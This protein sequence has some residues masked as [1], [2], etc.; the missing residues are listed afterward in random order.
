M[1][2]ITLFLSLIL[3]VIPFTEAFAQDTVSIQAF[4]YLSLTRDTVVGFPQ[5]GTSYEKILMTYNMRCHGGSVSTSG[6]NNGPNQGGCGEWDYSCNTYLTDSSRVD[7][8]YSFTPS[9]SVSG[10]NG[11]TL[12]YINQTTFSYLQTT[13][14]EVTVTSSN[15]SNHLLLS[16]A[17][18]QSNALRTNKNAGKSQFLYTASE[19]S[20]AGITAGDLFAL[21]LKATNSAR[22]GFLRVSMKNTNDVSLSEAALHTNGFTEVYYRNTDFIAG[23]NALQFYQP[24]NWDGTSNVIVEF[25]FTNSTPDLAL[26]LQGEVNIDNLALVAGGN[27]YAEFSGQ[28]LD[29]DPTAMANITN[30]LTITAWAYGNPDVLPANTYFLE[31]VNAANQRQVNVHL[32]WS[33]SRV[34]WDC[35]GD[36]GN[37]DRID[38]LATTA[39]IEGQWNHWAFTKNANTGDMKIFLN[40]VLW[41]SGTA[42][43]FTMDITNFVIGHSWTGNGAYSGSIDELTVWNKELDEATIQAWMNKTI[44][45]THPN[46]INLMAYFDFNEG[47]GLSTNDQSPNNSTGTFD[48]LPAWRFE[49]GNNIDRQFENV[50]FRPHVTFVQGT[51][52]FSVQDVTVMDSSENTPHAIKEFAIN[53]MYG[54]AVDD[55]IVEQSVLT[56]W[57]IGPF[58]ILDESGNIVGTTTYTSNG[59]VTIGEL[60]YYRRFPS[61]F[62]LMSF[63]T[64]YG[65]SLN[66]GPNGKTYL[67]DVTDFAPVLLG[68]KRISIERGG[69]WQE[70]LDIQFHFIKG[71]PPREVKN[72]QPIWRDA[73]PNYANISSGRALENRNI[74]LDPTGKSF[75][76]R[77]SITG[78][79]QEGEF[80]PRFHKLNLDGGAEEFNWQV[81]KSCGANPVYPQGGTWVYDRAGWCPG[82]ATD[83]Q[84]SVL[85]PYVTPGQTISIDYD[86]DVAT[87]DSR[88]IVNHLLVTYGDVN[89]TNDAAVIEI[90]RPSMRVEYDRTNPACSRPIVVI[91]N[92]GSANL[93]SLKILYSVVGGTPKLFNWTGSLEFMET[94]EVVLPVETLSFWTT[95]AAENIFEVVISEPNGLADEYANNNVYHSE[96]ESFPVYDG[97][98]NFK[99]KTNN[100]AFENKLQLFNQEGNLVFE[101]AGFSPNTVYVDELF[102]HPG[103]YTLTFLDSGNDGLSWWANPNQGSGYFQFK[104]GNAVKKSFGGDFGSVFHYDFYSTGSLGIDQNEAVSYTYLAPNPT[105]GIV[106]VHMNGQAGSEAV[107]EVFNTMGQKVM[108]SSWEL[109]GAVQNES[110]DLSALN[111]G[112]YIVRIQNSGNSKVERIV[113]Q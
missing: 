63:V 89:F 28:R 90:Q 83:V 44:D 52:T 56:A 46:Y 48:L 50:L 81:W 16:S 1:K 51:H 111:N 97:N 55:E 73:Y 64:P 14:K 10:F 109:N 105:N 42:K 41:H 40:G 6:N 61:R 79:G 78:H 71:T 96:F 30:E 17:A 92:T 43:I 45:A 8:L 27:A 57:P 3:I 37:Y 15:P 94:E 38:K 24:F 76:I 47:A 70:E 39:D 72:I 74:T 103:C 101:K 66:L 62:E 21:T 59:S 93:N 32:P 86:M 98:I 91:Q 26:D 67:F 54:A 11:T 75:K 113:K 58:D 77:S 112:V 85:D 106:N 4:S 31:G 20:T 82:M 102:L 100:S 12:D 84:H 9:H 87:G 23:N 22:A 60:T 69:Q 35:G 68:D 99:Y 104:V 18:S 95:S 5:P 36:G 80:I 110:I 34:Y 33:N 25:S 107:C 49:R 29:V 53:P 88:Y 65:N 108:E 19:L 13:Q 7:S 2:K